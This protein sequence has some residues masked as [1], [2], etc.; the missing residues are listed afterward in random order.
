MAD[1]MKYAALMFAAEG[2]FSNDPDDAGGATNMG[3]TIGTWR[4]VGHDL[5]GDG[6]IDAD[7]LKLLTREDVIRKVLKPHYWDRWQADRIRNQSVAD[8][9]VD[10]LYNSGSAGIRIP[11][12]ILGVKDDG[13]VGPDTLAAVNSADQ[14]RLFDS[15]MDARK[16]YYN[17]LAIRKP[18]QRRF[19]KGWMNR[20]A[21]FTFED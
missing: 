14:K 17:D 18:S 8:I 19:L 3:V 1:V 10:W 15:I 12:R 7:D 13:I 11:Q 9:L 5:D 16:R 4:D 2:G 6:D 21:G 20:L